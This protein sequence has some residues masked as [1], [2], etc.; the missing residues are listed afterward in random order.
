MIIF[1]SINILY[2]YLKC[3]KKIY[4]PVEQ[5]SFPPRK[6]TTI[7]RKKY[8]YL[9]IRIEIF[10]FGEFHV[11]DMVKK[12]NLQI[13]CIKLIMHCFTNLRYV[14]VQY[15]VE[16][17]LS[18]TFITPCTQYAYNYPLSIFVIHTRSNSSFTVIDAS[19]Y[20]ITW[21]SLS[22]IALLTTAH[23]HI[24]FY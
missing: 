10:S 23:I 15:M 17:S 4:K 20:G 5:F 14:Y 6:K 1:I 2:V 11:H 3:K 7:N 18:K 21:P 12:N 9:K 13:V 22:A 24:G 19:F 16:I 8:M